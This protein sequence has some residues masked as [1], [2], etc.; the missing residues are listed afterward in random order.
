MTWF[1]GQR[2][3]ISPVLRYLL[4]A[5]AGLG[6]S[7]HILFYSFILF[8]GFRRGPVIFVH[9]VLLAGGFFLYRSSAP[10]RFRPTSFHAAK[11]EIFLY[12][13]LGLALIPIWIT[14]RYYPLGGWDAWQVWNFKARFLF[15]AG[16]EWE[17]LFRPMLWRSS[18][19]YPLLLP[20]TNVWGWSLLKEPLPR[21][22]QATAFL[23]TFLTAGTLLAGV[24]HFTKH[25]VS[26]LAPLLLLTL[27]FFGLLAVSQYSDIVLS[28]YLLAAVVCMMLT[29]TPP[30]D[31]RENPRIDARYALLA[32]IFIG[33]LSFTK[34]EGMLAALLLIGI[35]FVAELW[36]RRQQRLGTPGLGFFLAG[37]VLAG[38]PSVIF[39]LAYSPGNQTFVNG[40]L[41][42]AKP[43]SCYRLKMI[44]AFLLVELKSEKWNGL[45]LLWA[46]G[47]IVGIKKCF[48]RPFVW[49]PAFLFLYL[50]GVISYYWLNTYFDIGWW[51]QS[52]LNRILFTLLPVVALWLF[53]ALWTEKKTP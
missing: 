47:I 2:C 17:R 6:L 51:L 46:G 25:V 45:W 4:G 40:F 26:A 16:N 39:V 41:S 24:Y 21:V 36:P 10:S 22:C 27:P 13:I 32:G 34:P 35:M 31:L 15:L 48:Q 44:L 20:L 8:D 28:F 29:F 23:F 11:K 43:V 12:S 50:G 9:L 18:P 52:S 42:D 30:R 3:R 37:V 14:A 33:F 5:G 1:L 7:T 53:V 19:H 49:I 38:L